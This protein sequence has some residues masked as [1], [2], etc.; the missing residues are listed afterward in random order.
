MSSQAERDAAAVGFHKN[1][2]QSLYE[3][4]SWKGTKRTY[5]I[6]TY[7]MEET[8][9]FLIETLISNDALLL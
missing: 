9:N 2:L 3:L 4:K 8:S 6:D 7:A 1:L 5:T